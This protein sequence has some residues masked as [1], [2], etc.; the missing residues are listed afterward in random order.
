MKEIHQEERAF[1][2]FL[3]TGD[4]KERTLQKYRNIYE[5]KIKDKGTQEAFYNDDTSIGH[6]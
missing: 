4:Q 2:A 5:L 3:S 6:P 1:T